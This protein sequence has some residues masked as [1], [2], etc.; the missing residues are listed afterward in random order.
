[1]RISFYGACRE[2]TGS[3]ILIE[4]NGHKII[5]ECGNFQGSKF[6]EEKNYSAFSYDPKS[7]DTVIIGHAHLDHT[8]RLPKLIKEGFT[9][10]I[11]STP[12]TK[13][14]TRLVLED[15]EKLMREESEKNHHA[16]LYSKEDVIKVIRQFETI[17]YN[18]TVNLNNEF[19]LTFK[20]AGHI[21]GSAITV[22]DIGS[23]RLIY[24]SDLG[25]TPSL[26]LDSPQIIEAGDYLICESTYAARVHED[27]NKRTEKLAEVINST[28][29]NNGVLLIPSFAIER[30]Q[31]MLHD[32]EHFCNV[33]NCEKP[34]FFLD[35]PLAEKVTAVFGQFP[36][37]L[38]EKLNKTHY[39]KDFFGLDRLHLISSVEES[40]NIKSIPNPKI[41]IA[42]SGMMNGGRILFHAMD[43]LG[44][45]NNILLF[46]GYQAFGTLGRR[47][48]E[49]EKE[50]K[51]YGKKIR[52]NAQ[53]KAIGSYSAHAD[54]PQLLN[55]IN[56]VKNL[57][58]I[59]IVHGENEQALE[60]AKAINS[61]FKIIADIPQLGE[62][63]YL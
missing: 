28:I 52:I 22:L 37:Y 3:N 35:S 14:L 49:G 26:L 48:Y 31:E 9:G 34:K 63:F 1:M 33:Q 41:I 21:L 44:N 10:K 36:D 55:W 60:F 5:L 61:K 38:S 56:N 23:K 19:K 32:I 46:I 62:T 58:K 43:Y 8:G 29:I 39:D 25:N 57:K 27:L 6:A 51:I 13:E 47:I 12:P 30:T 59:F 11:Y 24:T 17:T 54:Q 50:I 45:K 42:G 7:I 40:K 2:V 20:N 18:Q 16:P 4:E 15:S 53:I